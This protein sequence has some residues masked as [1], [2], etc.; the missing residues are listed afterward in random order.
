MWPTLQQWLKNWYILIIA[1]CLMILPVL[2]FTPEQ[3]TRTQAAS[4]STESNK[5][6]IPANVVAAKSSPQP[7]TVQAQ[8][9]PQSSSNQPT[10]PPPQKA[11]QNAPAPAAPPPPPA[12]VNSQAAPHAAPPAQTTGQTQATSEATSGDTAAGRQVFRKCQACH[13]LEPGKNMLGPSLADLIGRKAGSEVGYNYSTAMKQANITW[14]TKTLDAYLADPPKTVPGNKMPFPGLKTDHDRAD[15]IAFLAASA[16]P[17][18][19]TAAQQSGAVPSAQLPSPPPAQAPQS[20]P[21]PSVSYVPDARYTLRSGIAEGRMVY[22]GV[23]GS[24]DGKVN[25]VLTAAQG[26]VV[27]LTLINGEGAEHDIVFA[28]QNTRSPRITGKGASTTIAF[29]AAKAGDFT[30]FCSV[31]G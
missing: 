2:L 30:Y 29:R 20:T 23:G 26:Q 10:P 17:Q 28:D 21:G 22:I 13:S 18:G 9:S 14:D 8:K 4:Q 7:G 11:A 27:Q 15:I 12:A 1:L 16:G 19:A 31:P 6:E 24:I 25:P 5:A 3:N